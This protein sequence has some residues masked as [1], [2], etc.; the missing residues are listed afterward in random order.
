[1]MSQTIAHIGEF[2]LIRRIRNLIEKEGVKSP[3]VILGIGDDA[4]SFFPREGY[5][6]LVTCDS[7]VEGRHYLPEHISPFDLGR[8]A[9]AV[10]ISDIGAMGGRPLYGLISLG[11]KS[12]TELT[13]IE[14]M[15]R[16]FLAELKPFGAC[17]IGGNLARSEKGLFIDVT[18]IGEVEMGKGVQRSTAKAGDAILVTGYPGESGAGLQLLSLSSSRPELKAHPLIKAHLSPTHKAREG[19]AVGHTGFA[20]AMIDT[21]DGFLGDLGHVCEESGV[22]AVLFAEKF[23]VSENL[24]RAA[25]ILGKEPLALFMGD[26]DDYELIITC[27]ENHVAK[28]RSAIGSSFSGLVSEVGRITEREKGIRLVKADGSEEEIRARGWDH[29]SHGCIR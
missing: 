18:L 6:L 1:M 25:E 21:S 17:I 16:G 8:R 11:L 2:G 14:E 20:T 23:P 5:E 27:A 22:G 9:M 3:G 7:V 15:Y 12:D 19:A 29:F 13:Y 4:A 24:K 10:N 26:S 28:I